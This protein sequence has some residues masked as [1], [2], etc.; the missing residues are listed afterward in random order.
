MNIDALIDTNILV[1]AYDNADLD[2]H[3]KA[4]DILLK[5]Y[6]GQ[7]RYAVSTQNLL[8]LYNV[9]TKKRSTPLGHQEAMDIVID[10][11]TFEGWTVIRPDIS[12][13]VM[14][15]NIAGT[16]ST[17]IWDAHIIAVMREHEIKTVIT[18]NTKDF[19]IPGIKAI[20]PF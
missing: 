5:V 16:Y 15:I 18:E 8:E 2:K 1:Y 12:C 7:K 9:L 17:S 10:V 3:Q 20:N 4:K 14:A 11:M 13:L 6:N 19:R